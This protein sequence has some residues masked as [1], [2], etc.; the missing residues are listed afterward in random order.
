MKQLKCFSLF[1]DIG[2]EDWQCGCS[3]SIKTYIN[4]FLSFYSTLDVDLTLFCEESFKKLLEP[5]V[6]NF[7]NF[8]SKVKFEIIDRKDL[9]YFDRL[10]E[11]SKIQKSEKLRFAIRGLS[12][13][14][15][16]YN[17]PEYVATM[18]SKPEVLSIA[19]QRNLISAG[20]QV[21]W[22]DFGIA[23]SN[24]QFINKLRGKTLVQNNICDKVIL[25]NRK[26]ERLP[27]SID[28]FFTMPDNVF[29]PGGFFVVPAQLIENFCTEFNSVAK[30]HLFDAGL[31][32]DDQSVLT[33]V[34]NNTDLC[35]IV[36]STMWKNNPPEGDWFP[37]FDFLSEVE[38]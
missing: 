8:R 25:F 2:R 6:V 26:K 9:S 17:R 16:E 35:Q 21:A 15:P 37:V 14:V 5:I 1:I 31:I 4:H 19:K 12:S 7:P 13:N 33:L 36:D 18:F 24:P 38:V 28:V 30:Q 20:D 32:D 27:K 11:I 22:I 29:V 3:R 23:H 34:S 10:D